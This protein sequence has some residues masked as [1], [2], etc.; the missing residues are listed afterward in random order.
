MD[1]LLLFN[2]IPT[3][4]FEYFAQINTVFSNEKKKYPT[5]KHES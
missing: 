3:I 5:F 2:I 1:Q 4:I